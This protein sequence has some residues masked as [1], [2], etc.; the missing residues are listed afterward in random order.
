MAVFVICFRVP[1]IGRSSLAMA[2]S[3]W[4]SF[5]RQ[6]LMRMVRSAY[7][8]APYRARLRGG[9]HRRS[10]DCG[11]ARLKLGVSSDDI[12]PQEEPR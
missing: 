10:V 3:R 6:Q 1:R 9:R 4:I 7:A 12:S 2:V 8:D 5:A 11:G